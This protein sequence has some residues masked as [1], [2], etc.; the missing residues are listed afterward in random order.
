M[1]SNK[2]LAAILV[3]GIIAYLAGFIGHKLVEP[4]KLA[5]NAYKI[6]GVAPAS[7]GARRR[8]QQVRSLS[9]TCWP[10]RAWRMARRFQKSAVPATASTPANPTALARTWPVLLAVRAQL[11]LVSHTRMP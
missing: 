10:K 9:K 7:G 8:R 11:L 3:A 5:E 1:E 2:I 4:E 6:E